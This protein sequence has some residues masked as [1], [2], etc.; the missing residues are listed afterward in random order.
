MS[1]GIAMIQEWGLHEINSWQGKEITENPEDDEDFTD[2][3]QKEQEDPF[4]GS[5]ED[6][7]LSWRDFL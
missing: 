3:E 4:T 6:Y 7:G 1:Y 5:M 2:M